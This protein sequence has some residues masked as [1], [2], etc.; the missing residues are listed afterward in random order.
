MILADPA[1]E[2]GTLI[3]SVLALF[4]SIVTYITSV[5]QKQTDQISDLR[6]QL[7]ATLNEVSTVNISFA[8]LLVDRRDDFS[9]EVIQ[10]RR[11][12]NG[13]R[14][15]LMTQAELILKEIA[16]QGTETEY[17]HM[18][19]AA[20]SVG[21]Y[22]SAEKYWQMAI[23]KSD[24]QVI[25]LYNMRGYARFL[26][27]QGSF[28]EGRKVFGEALLLRFP[29]T[30]NVKKTVADTY[31]MWAREERNFRFDDQVAQLVNL[32]TVHCERITHVPMRKEMKAQI[33][34]FRHETWP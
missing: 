29:D 5:R 31:L 9:T 21:N 20:S 27:Q 22:S 15:I 4:I 30:E 23:A 10:L 1:V 26:F 13:R 2:T 6:K 3:V 11:A 34:N 7:S 17:E 16:D 32:A 14:R 18:A 33:D 25:K 24:D 8:T 28:A 12:L 19:I